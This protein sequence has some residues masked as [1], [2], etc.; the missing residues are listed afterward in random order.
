MEASGGSEIGGSGRL[1]SAREGSWVQLEW[2]PGGGCGG[3][4]SM[5]KSRAYL[6]LKGSG[7]GLR[8]RATTAC[9]RCSV[10]WWSSGATACARDRFCAIV[11]RSLGS[12]G[13]TQRRCPDLI[14][15]TSVENKVRRGGLTPLCT[16]QYCP[17]ICFSFE[18]Q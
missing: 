3:G 14:G 7:M 10:H 4:A 8:I 12:D 17:F 6:R 1:P 5:A 2:L 9:I 16:N 13:F 18:L 11:S 15:E